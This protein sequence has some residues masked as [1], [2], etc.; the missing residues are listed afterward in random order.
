LGLV[1]ASTSGV[2]PWRVWLFAMAGAAG[3]AVG[4]KQGWPETRILSFAGGWALLAAASDGLGA[5]WLVTIGGVVL[6]APIWWHAVRTSR[7][8]PD[9]RVTGQTE[10]EW[11]VGET[12][13]FYVTPL[14]AG[15]AV[16]HLAPHWFELHPGA[17]PLALGLAYLAA[18]YQQPRYPFALV[19]AA[20]LA[21]AALATWPAYQSVFVLLAL[22]LIW[23]GLDHWLARMDGRWYAVGTL[24]IAILQLIVASASRGSGA[25]FTDGWASAL[26]FTI[27]VCGILASGLWMQLPG[28]LTPPPPKTSLRPQT[29][30]QSWVGAREEWAPQMPAALWTL[31]GTLLLV[32]VT[33]ELD[34]FF[35]QSD[36]PVE[37]AQL[38]SGLSISAWWA[39]FAGGLVLLGFRRNRRS[40]RVAGLA[41]AGLAVAK[42][43]L[44]DLSNLDALYRV[45]SVFILGLVSLLVAYLYHRKARAPAGQ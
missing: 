40:I 33:G 36:L 6:T 41:V 4:L 20:G 17:A 44:V 9:P 12:I 10:A 42:V 13:P 22:A 8:W 16:T 34:R 25:A 19:G 30:T 18:G 27:V 2:T 5:H 11:S 7:I 38:W 29:F 43:L 1:A 24:A 26:W 37:Q 32:G 21:W 3:I 39:V 45:G 31:A 35:S 28:E 15:W 14:L 23:A